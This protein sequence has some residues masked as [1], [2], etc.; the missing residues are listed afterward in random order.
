MER[1][2]KENDPA[3][4]AVMIQELRQKYGSPTAESLPFR[5]HWI[6]WET[7]MGDED[8]KA[9]ATKILARLYPSYSFYTPAFVNAAS[10]DEQADLVRG[11]ARTQSGKID[12]AIYKVFQTAVQMDVATENDEDSFE[13]LCLA[14]MMRLAGRGH[15]EE[16]REYVDRRLKAVEALP[17]GSLGR[18]SLE[19]L[20]E[21]QKRLKK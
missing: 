9:T 16:F 5:L 13:G 19:A 8:G 3:R 7:N 18:R 2:V 21:W 15:D 10:A 4:W 14:C 20:R 1:L 12:H 11:L 17:E 6:Y